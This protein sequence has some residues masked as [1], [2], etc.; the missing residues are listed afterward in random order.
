MKRRLKGKIVSNKMEKTLVVAVDRIKEHPLYK[1]KFRVTTKFKVHAENSKDFNIGD[2]VTIEESKP[3]SKD[4]RWVVIN[5][6][7]E[8]KDQ[9][10]VKSKKEKVN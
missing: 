4:K 6:K 2:E 1:K 3:L 5:Q 10:E 9:K 7:S 8:I